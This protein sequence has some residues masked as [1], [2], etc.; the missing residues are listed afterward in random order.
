MRH[1]S[2][3]SP[4]RAFLVVALVA[5]ACGGSTTTTPPA[6]L[7]A[8]PTL[9]VATAAPTVAPSQAPTL[10]PT[11]P[12]TAAPTPGPTASPRPS[13]SGTPASTPEASARGESTSPATTAGASRAGAT[14]SGTP[15]DIAP[16]L[17]ARVSV[18]D[19][20]TAAVDLDVALLG[21]D[22][23]LTSV[24][25]VH[26]E[27]FDAHAQSVVPATYQ[28][29]WTFA[30]GS[31]PKTVCRLKIDDGEVVHFAVLSKLVTVTRD[32]ET[33]TSGT[34]LLVGTSPLCGP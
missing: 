5:G 30:G 21:D 25:Q 17:T 27:P 15:I 24:L 20:G 18:V 11:S 19:L 34:D 22:G 14:P 6:S 12:P 16:F 29:T 2:L 33:P 3:A 9:P 7:P 31:A 13:P 23:A 1:R 4:S 28:L 8:L 10:E 26:L 32:G